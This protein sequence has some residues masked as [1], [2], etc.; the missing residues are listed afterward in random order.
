MEGVNIRDVSRESFDKAIDFI[1][2][3]VSF[4]SLRYVLPVASDLFDSGN[5]AV[6]LIKPQ[7]ECGRADLGKNGIVRDASVGKRVTE[8][9]CAFAEEVG[10]IVKGVTL[11]PVKG[12]GKGNVTGNTEYLMHI[13]KR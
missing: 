4:I 13:V 3:D 12:G 6:M 5:G 11:S 2:C 7:F 10:F 9:I 1:G 8:E